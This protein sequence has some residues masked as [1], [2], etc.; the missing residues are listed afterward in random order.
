VR[1]SQQ[2]GLGVLAAISALPLIL[3]LVHCEPNN[4]DAPAM[5]GVRCTAKEDC[6]YYLVCAESQCR[7]R[8][9]V[10]AYNE[11]CRSGGCFL[12]PDYG[13][14][15]GGPYSTGTGTGAQCGPTISPLR[16]DMPGGYYGGSP[17]MTFDSTHV[18]AAAS[19]SDTLGNTKPGIYAA[20]LDG[21]GTFHPVWTAPSASA[22]VAAVATVARSGAS[23]Y[24]MEN[25]YMSTLRRLPVP[26][27]DPAP[28]PE[29]LAIK[30]E[31][32]AG[33]PSHLVLRIQNLD[34]NSGAG[35]SNFNLH[36]LD[37]STG[38]LDPSRIDSYVGHLGITSSRMFWTFG[39]DATRST[40]G[41]AAGEIVTASLDS[42]PA[43]ATGVFV[44]T[45]TALTG[46][47]AAGTDVYFT[48]PN[49]TLLKV[50]TTKKGSQPTTVR[51]AG[52]ASFGTIAD[53]GYQYAVQTNSG[54]GSGYCGE[55][56]RVSI[57][58]NEEQKLAT[59][60]TGAAVIAITPDSVYLRDMYG[61]AG[62]LYRVKKP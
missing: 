1:A 54:S 58:T 59:V 61:N 41:A 14:T 39:A 52:S 55:L 28:T 46:S 3:L 9:G 51:P 25:G 2:I 22:A 20:T 15:S 40:T 36:R 31:I 24:F 13:G 37:G 32:V 29:D 42:G 10:C 34:G 12:R 33:T 5:V 56:K 27:P 7:Q 30:G 18:Y 21:K 17:A 45:G 11:E 35:V 48:T 44:P 38:A 23:L 49:N 62:A 6:P 4:P 43:T 53:D 60:P 8:C 19:V 16:T 50:D 47:F 57:T 26:V